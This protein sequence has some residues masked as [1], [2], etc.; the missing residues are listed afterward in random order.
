M[1]A[2]TTLRISVRHMVTGDVIQREVSR[3]PLTIGRHDTNGLQLNDETVS[4]M[5]ATLEWEGG[6]VV[7]TD[8]GS[9]NGIY[10]RGFRL[11]SYAP[12]TLGDD[13]LFA[14]GPFVVRGIV[15][16]MEIESTDAPTRAVSAEELRRLLP[17]DGAVTVVRR[18]M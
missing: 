14:I 4:R 7:L 6:E 10:Q 18:M 3:L 8:L 1:D 12:H 17:D 5:H 9:L 16:R 11:R 13:F 15:E 2:G